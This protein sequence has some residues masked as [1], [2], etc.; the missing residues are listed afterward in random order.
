MYK[1]SYVADGET[2]EF[3]F[4][5]PFFQNADIRVAIDNIVLNT[6]NYSVNPNANFDGGNI[7]FLT[8]PATDSVIDIFRKI[9]LTRTVD[10]QPTVKIDP[11]SL[12]SDFNFLLAAFQDFNE[13]EIDL[14]QWQNI[15]DN[16]LS[17]LEYT[18]LLIQDKIGGGA[19]L[20][21]YN[22]LLSVLNNALPTLINDYG[23]IT[24]SAIGENNDDYGL[25]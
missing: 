9:S 19:V 3:S 17:F 5:F 20:G 23:S 6:E 21:L 15:H 1:I 13:I 25:L 18:N 8:P 4:V 12:N 11:E 22:N 16:V 24:E 7:I 10:Y 2:T 14:A